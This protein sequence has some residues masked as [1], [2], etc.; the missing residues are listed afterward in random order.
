MRHGRLRASSG[1]ICFR[2]VY[3]A[4]EAFVVV[5]HE[6]IGGIFS[7]LT[8]VSDCMPIVSVTKTKGSV[9]SIRF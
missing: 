8:N 6:N 5:W 9:A 4:V 1:L 2:P 7:D 3:T